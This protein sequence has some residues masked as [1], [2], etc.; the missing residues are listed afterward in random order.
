MSLAIIIYL[1]HTYNNSPFKGNIQNCTC[2]S[3]LEALSRAHIQQQ[4]FE[5]RF[6]ELY[7]YVLPSGIVSCIQQQPS[8]RH[9]CFQYINNPLKGSFQNHRSATL[10]K[11]TS[12]HFHDVGTSSRFHGVRIIMVLDT[13]QRISTI[14]Y[15]FVVQDL[16]QT[17]TV[18]ELLHTSTA[19][20][21]LWCSIR[22]NGSAQSSML[23]RYRTLSTL[24]RCRTFPTLP[25]CRNHYGAQYPT[26]D[27][28]NCPCFHSIGPFPHFH[29]VG[30]S[31]F[32]FQESIMVL[33]TQQRINTIVHTSIV[34]DPFHTSTVQELLLSCSRSHY[35]A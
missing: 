16:L 33:D 19:Q 9:F 26:T 35:G 7:T 10:L 25:W 18:Q 24:P 30:T 4:P 20:E 32:L 12:P 6:P 1:V 14:I 28:H 34:Q 2:K 22:N 21:S 31:S 17:S 15:A 13:Q 27:Q 11:A 3:Y 23:P 29:N 5:R 8:Q